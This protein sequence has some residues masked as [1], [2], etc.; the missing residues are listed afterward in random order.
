MICYSVFSSVVLSPLAELA[1]ELEKE[2]DA[3]EQAE[4]EKQE[5]SIFIPFP[6]TTKMVQPPP[7]GYKDPEWSEFVKI[8]KNRDLQKDLKGSFFVYS[9]GK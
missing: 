3:E 8:S 6:G 9:S 5:D 2:L 4:L 7:Y 1:E